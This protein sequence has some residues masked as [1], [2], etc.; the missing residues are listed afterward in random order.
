[1]ANS[2]NLALYKK[3]FN[4]LPSNDAVIFSS[5]EFWNLAASNSPAP[6]LDNVCKRIKS[7]GFDDVLVV[8]FVRNQVGWIESDYLQSIKDGSM[9]R[10]DEFLRDREYIRKRYDLGEFTRACV[11][12]FG[13]K[14]V[15]VINFDELRQRRARVEYYFAR[16]LSR[17]HGI[18]IDSLPLNTRKQNVSQLNVLSVALLTRFNALFPFS[19]N[20][21]YN[22]SREA[23][24]RKG[25]IDRLSTYGQAAGLGKWHF[26]HDL[27]LTVYHS[28][29]DERSVSAKDF[30]HHEFLKK[31]CLSA[32]EKSNVHDSHSAAIDFPEQIIDLIV[33]DCIA[34]IDSYQIHSSLS[35]R[36][37]IT[38]EIVVNAYRLF[39]S[40]DPESEAVISEKISD[41]TTLFDLCA[42]LACSAE[43]SDLLFFDSSS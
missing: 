20:G 41:C 26:P 15:N 4:G 39:L 35:A 32:V 40:R 12:V 16:Y 24:V 9:L 38:K 33:N 30:I 8:F 27:A 14:N 17:E 31:A 3:V 6:Y 5:E 21:S 28:F 22:S 13:P 10:P 36:C 19:P 7:F 11:E 34:S 2:R 18:T 1:M 25:I 42:S 37:A 23:L 43:F 29:Y